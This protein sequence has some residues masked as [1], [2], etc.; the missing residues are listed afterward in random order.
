M[1]GEREGLKK[2]VRNR[3]VG[4]ESGRGKGRKEIIESNMWKLERE[5]TTSVLRMGGGR[6]WGLKTTTSTGMLQEREGIKH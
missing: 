2:K 3:H 5:G 6:K 1:G 4:G